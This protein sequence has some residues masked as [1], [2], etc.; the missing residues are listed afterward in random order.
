M[1]SRKKAPADLR[2]VDMFTGRTKLEET[3]AI[4]EASPEDEVREETE[5]TTMSLAEKADNCAI[6][7]LGDDGPPKGDDVKLALHPE[8]HAVMV[9]VSSYGPDKAPYGTST[10]KLSRVQ[11]MKLVELVRFES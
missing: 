9:L 1:A 11:W 10:I 2:T 6:R 5:V 3:R 8:G 7:W 4:P